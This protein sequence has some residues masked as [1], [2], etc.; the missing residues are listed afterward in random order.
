ML[1]NSGLHWIIS[2]SFLFA[3]VHWS[4]FAANIKLS[5]D[6]C[7]YVCMYVFMHVCISIS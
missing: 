1:L 2:L 7:M 4:V 3:F 5:G 6:V